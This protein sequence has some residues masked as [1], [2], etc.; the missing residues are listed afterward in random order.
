MLL[1][2]SQSALESAKSKEI[3][4]VTGTREG[5][6]SEMEE[7]TESEYESE[8]EYNN[9]ESQVIGAASDSENGTDESD[10]ELI[11]IE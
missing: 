4:S 3:Q 11:F 2:R 8:K 6:E 1:N 10:D 7:N 9:A 5:T